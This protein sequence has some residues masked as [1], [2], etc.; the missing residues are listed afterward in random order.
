MKKSFIKRL[1]VMIISGIVIG[2]G[3]AFFVKAELGA[4]SMT[5][6][7]QG[8]S[9][10]LNID[11]ALCSIIANGLFAILTLLI[12]AKELTIPTLIYPLFISLGIKLTNMFLPNI[13]ND[14][15]R[16][17]YMFIGLVTIGLGI[18]LGSNCGCGNNP[19]DGFV[20]CLSKKINIQY[21]YVRMVLDAVILV[22]GIVLKGSFGIGTIV[23]IVLQGVIAQWFIDN[24]KKSKRLN[25]FIEAE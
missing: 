23:A 6:F 13:S 2:L 21:K 22:V 24:L 16:I 1:F 11:L 25:K 17:V 14:Q 3:I 18:G 8:L 19:Y 12:S 15:L 7:E 9:I 10:T 20:L 4:D 5:T